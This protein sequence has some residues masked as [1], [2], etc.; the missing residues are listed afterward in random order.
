MEHIHWSDFEKV[1]IKTGTI[2]SA[3]S[4]PEARKP[5]YQLEIDFGSDGIL[6]S[7]AQITH[8]Y[9]TDELVG[10]Q[11]VAVINFPPKQIGPFMSQCLVLGAVNAD[12]SVVLL[13]TSK[14]TNNGL[15]IA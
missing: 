7:S 6:K 8:H 5:A 11:V 2:I 10:M 13:Q 3:R 1:M 12:G 9:T 15:R 4:F 14:K